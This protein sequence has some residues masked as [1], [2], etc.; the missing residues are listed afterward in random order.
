LSPHV[1]QHYYKLFIQQTTSQDT[2]LFDL[3]ESLRNLRWA[4]LTWD[5]MVGN[6]YI[7]IILFFRLGVYHTITKKYIYIGVIFFIVIYIYIV[8]CIY[9]YIFI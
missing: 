3:T 1:Y 9:T 4:L 6:M 7:Y 5:D 2:F 8:D